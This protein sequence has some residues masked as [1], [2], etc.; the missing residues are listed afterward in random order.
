MKYQIQPQDGCF[1]QY[2]QT[3]SAELLA[4]WLHCFLKSA[5][6]STTATSWQRVYP[7]ISEMTAC[8][9][10]AYVM[11][12]INS[13][14]PSWGRELYSVQ[15]ALLDHG[16]IDIHG[17]HGLL[18]MLLLLHLCI[19]FS[20]SLAWGCATVTAGDQHQCC[21]FFKPRPVPV[22]S[23]TLAIPLGSVQIPR[24]GHYDSLAGPATIAVLLLW[25]SE[26]S[27]EKYLRFVMLLI[28]LLLLL[29]LP[30]FSYQL[31]LLHC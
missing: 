30:V 8:I 28:L 6:I 23:R 1:L 20:F 18:Y 4:K 19:C 15:S 21:S 22:S 7:G 31:V 12:V 9:G 27:C 14:Q 3:L 13:V 29:L 11:A 5:L 17:Y 10:N 26:N 16:P 24:S 25:R 2:S